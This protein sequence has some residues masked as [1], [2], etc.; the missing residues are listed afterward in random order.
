MQ[1]AL[2]EISGIAGP[3]IRDKGINDINK[4]GKRSYLS[5]SLNII[6]S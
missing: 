1:Q 2:T 4:Y 3:V 6:F 5:I